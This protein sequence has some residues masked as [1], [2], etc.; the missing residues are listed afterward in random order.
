MLGVL[1][2]EAGGDVLAGISPG[3][4]LSER[5]AQGVGL[6]GLS[7]SAGPRWQPP[8]ARHRICGCRML[9]NSRCGSLSALVERTRPFRTF[10]C[11]TSPC[12]H[13]TT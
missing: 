4:A 7:S 8:F 6:A 11:G 12:W 5:G 9:M 3:L 2:D 1:P 10:W 13:S